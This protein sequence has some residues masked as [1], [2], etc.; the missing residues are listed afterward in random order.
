MATLRSR[1]RNRALSFLARRDP[2]MEDICTR[3]EVLC[4]AED[5]ETPPGICDPRDFKRVTACEATTTMEEEGAGTG[6]GM[7][8]HG[9]MTLYASAPCAMDRSPGRPSRVASASIR[10]NC[11]ACSTASKQRQIIQYRYLYRMFHVEHSRGKQDRAAANLRHSG[12]NRSPKAL[13]R[14]P[15]SE[16]P[17]VTV[18]NRNA[19]CQ[20]LLPGA[21]RL[22][23]KLTIFHSP[24]RWL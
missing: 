11:S 20:R 14:G 23:S 18:P 6:G 3:R 10:T 24:E 19:E 9:A 15:P 21:R 22:A 4:L 17:R 5:Q 2:S 12:L 8:H 7:R 1:I 13:L 16:N